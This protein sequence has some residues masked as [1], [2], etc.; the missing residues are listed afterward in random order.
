MTLKEALMSHAVGDSVWVA[1]SYIEPNGKSR[2]HVLRGD[3]VAVIEGNVMVRYPSSGTIRALVDGVQTP[4]DSEAD[5]WGVVARELT[6]AR[7]RVQAAI[8]E[9]TAKA[10]GSRVGEAVPA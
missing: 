3:V 6:A 1:G 8:D 9:A 5:A 10:A 7:D 2:G 4:C